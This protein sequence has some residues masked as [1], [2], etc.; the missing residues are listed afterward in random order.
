MF[1]I[2]II[3]VLYNLQ[4]RF[5]ERNY[6]YT[7]CGMFPLITLHLQWTHCLQ[8]KIYWHA[9]GCFYDQC[10]MII[11][12][13][14]QQ[15][16]YLLPAFARCIC[17]FFCHFQDFIELNMNELLKKTAIWIASVRELTIWANWYFW[18]F[19]KIKFIIHL[20]IYNYEMQIHKLSS[21]INYK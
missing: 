16:L 15:D 10:N 18:R 4:V 20:Q 1:I 17:L 5:C 21:V 2:F 7:Y 9:A 13:W 12:G 3:A 19:K 6:I 11:V 8:M 14:R